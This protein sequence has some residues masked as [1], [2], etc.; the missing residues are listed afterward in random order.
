M[1]IAIINQK[2]GCGKTTLATNLSAAFVEQGADVALIDADPQGS[3]DSWVQL[4]NA[5]H[6]PTPPTMTI[7]RESIGRELDDLRERYAQLIVDTASGM[8]PGALRT[9]N[10]IITRA[11]LVLVPCSP[12]F[13]DLRS[14]AEALDLIAQRREITDGRQP[15]ARV[16]ITQTRAGTVAD[17]EFR[18]YV[19]DQEIPILPT[20]MEWREDYRRYLADGKSVLDLPPSSKARAEFLQLVKE[21]KE[22]V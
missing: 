19:K 3:S 2:G 5:A 18:A 13:Y 20:A 7:T 21:V 10:A 9:L 11:D 22:V 12:S 16:V 8:H 15:Q 6:R 1:I 4:A 17:Q 14:S